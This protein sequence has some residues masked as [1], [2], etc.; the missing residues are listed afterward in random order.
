MGAASQ[1]LALAIIV[2][3]LVGVALGRLPWLRTD[4]ATIAL[5]GAVALVGLGCM[6]LDAAY[7]AIDLNTLAL[8]FALMVVT[9]HLR[10]SGLFDRAARWL[11]RHAHAPASLLFMSMAAA[12]ALSAL[13]LNDTIALALT[14]LM[15][16]AA[17]SL[18]RSAIPYLVGLGM[19]T[20]LGSV[21]TLIGN[22]QNILIG[23]S[24]GI[25]FVTFS[26]A[27]LPVAML[28]LLLAY[29][30]V[31]LVYRRELLE[32]VSLV[33]T[34]AVLPAAS[35]AT[36]RARKP[37]IAAV[38][39]LILMLAGVAPALAALAAA[40]LLLLSRRNDPR[41]VLAEIDWSLLVFFAG[42]FVVT[43]AAAYTPLTQTLHAH[44]AHVSGGNVW[45][46]TAVAAVASNL[47][48]NVPAVLLFRPLLAHVPQAELAWLTLA[49]ASTL[50]GNLTLLGSIANLI[51]AESARREGVHLGFGIFLKAGLP[52]TA[53]TLVL[54]AAWL[55]WRYAA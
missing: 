37:L 44:A 36:Y 13:F 20:N 6:P 47:I 39:M 5:S 12:A 8:L 53:A 38:I 7:A 24:S 50:A 55:S 54:G 26:A 25:P 23:T 22:P 33:E 9:A 31:W 15:V 28:G 46:L 34:A 27:L 21:A 40:A 2:L 52:V 10:L 30:I 51:V 18:G 16:A 48:S 45:G 3:T 42:L 14:P 19:A 41:R 35:P 29:G 32:P 43:G 49:M 17:R 4:R 1:Y 11:I